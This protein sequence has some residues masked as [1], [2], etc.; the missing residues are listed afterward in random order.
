MEQWGPEY[1]SAT[2]LAAAPGVTKA[3]ALF[4]G[5]LWIGAL[6]VAAVIASVGLVWWRRRLRNAWECTR[7]SFTLDQLRRLHN[8]GALTAAEYRFLRRRAADSFH[9]GGRNE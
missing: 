8:K 5:A 2:I 6:V 1:R 7:P 9:K 4:E 3:A